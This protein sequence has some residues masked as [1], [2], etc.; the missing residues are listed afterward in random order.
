MQ[1][2]QPGNLRASLNHYGYIPQMAEQIS[3]ITMRKLTVPML[4]WAGRASFGDHRFDCAK[5]I[6]GRIMPPEE[7]RIQLLEEMAGDGRKRCTA[8]ISAR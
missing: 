2:R 3:E 5:A 6:A 7:M 8:A 4:A 1:M